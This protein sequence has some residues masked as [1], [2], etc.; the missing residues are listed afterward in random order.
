MQ[1]SA[2]TR[3]PLHAIGC[4]PGPDW[5][6]RELMIETDHRKTTTKQEFECSELFGN[7]NPDPAGRNSDLTAVTSLGH[8]VATALST[9][10]P[11]P[12]AP[13]PLSSD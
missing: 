13:A 5:K 4:E 6:T 8:E 9:I 3:G 12:R 2:V 7:T 10:F 11:C 1:R